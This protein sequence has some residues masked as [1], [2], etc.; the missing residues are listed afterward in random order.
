MLC[1]LVIFVTDNPVWN[2]D[3]YIHTGLEEVE[4]AGAYNLIRDLIDG[5]LFGGKYVK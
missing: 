5:N 2:Q 3:T 4:D 1:H